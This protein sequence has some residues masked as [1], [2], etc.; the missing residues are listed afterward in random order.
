M[1]TKITHT[2]FKFRLLFLSLIAL[3]T[4]YMGYRAQEIQWSFDF[5]K[6]VPATDPDMVYFE[7]FKRSFGEDGNI[8]VIGVN[9]SSLYTPENFRKFNALSEEIKKHN[10]VTNV[11]SL[12][13]LKK[14]EKDTKRKQFDLVPIFDHVPDDQEKLEA[15]LRKAKDIKF[16]SGQLINTETG[17]TII[18]ISIDK[19]ILNSKKRDVLIQDLIRTANAFS[20]NTGIEV[21]Y[22]GLPYVRSIMTS[23]VGQELQFFLMLSV[24]ILGLIVFLFFRSWT[25]VLFPMVIIGIVVVWIL[26]T[27]A[28]LDY[29]VTLLTGMLPPIIVVIGIP[30]SVYLLNKYH[31]E[32][33]GHG[34]KLLAL[35]RVVRKIGLV[36]LITNLTTAIGFGVF[37]F[38]DILILREFGIVAALNIMATFLVSIILIPSVFSFLP[39]PTSRQLRHL[40]FKPLGKI[41]AT[42]D[43]LV[44]QRRLAIFAATLVMVGISIVGFNQLHAVS[45]MVDDFPED[46]KV[47]RD[48]KFFEKHFSGV[49]PLEIV[50]DTNQKRGLLRLKNLQKIEELEDYMDEQKYISKPISMISYVKASRQ[51]FY[52]NNP[53]RYSLP[54]NR[55]KKFILRYLRNDNDSTGVFKAF[56]DSSYQKMRVSLK[57]A[58]IG[59]NRMDSLVTEALIPK[60]NELFA[61][62]DIEAFV[63]GTTLLFIKGNRFLID[64]LKL[65]LM[66]AIGIIALIMAALFRNWKIM[67]ISLVPNLIPLLITAGIMGFFNVPLKPSTAL[68]F[69]IAFGISVD[70]SIHLLAK[71]RMELFANRFFVPIAISK[72]I[73]EIGPSMVYTSVILFAGFVIFTYSDF[74]GT[75]ALGML[76]SIT[77]LIALF[78]NLLLLPALLLT[79][80]SGKRSKD[81]HP[82]I[83]Q[84]GEALEE[85]DEREEREAKQ[86]SLNNRQIE[87]GREIKK[88]AN[89]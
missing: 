25:A 23:K 60:I 70:Y 58:D 18:L 2:I 89:P 3:I 28:I 56:I 29:K 24:A 52:N 76:T 31:Q 72:S 21:H 41:L 5:A 48:L 42:F 40:G 62:T 51:A 73:R 19:D 50:I 32:Y 79:F 15:L 46:S 75:V 1:W 20:E 67:L 53:N 83:E 61:D 14:L 80:D 57:V 68:I 7:N 34:N 12:P 64:N 69:S 78:T 39:P 85:S 88:E 77:L 43:H 27:L 87:K 13:N 63:T 66:L 74:G 9:D 47:I 86:I 82:P 54:D 11:L 71:Y 55:D 36:T 33:A 8:F 16:Y 22:A 10:G 59:S 81:E 44:H 17:A 6:I 38:I 37:A 4:V 45:Y 49:M 84:Y 30:N 65:S 26:G 35:S